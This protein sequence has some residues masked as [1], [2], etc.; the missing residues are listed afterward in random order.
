M[1]RAEAAIAELQAQLFVIST[2]PG[3]HPPYQNNH[4]LR[5]VG[6]P[7]ATT[8]KNTWRI[9]RPSSN[10]S[11]STG[12]AKSLIRSQGNKGGPDRAGGSG[13]RGD[14]G[15]GDSNDY[16]GI[17]L[18]S[19]V[20]QKC[21]KPN[22]SSIFPGLLVPVRSPSNS[23]DTNTFLCQENC[24]ESV[25]GETI[26]AGG[27]DP[28]SGGRKRRRKSSK[29]NFVGIENCDS[30]SR[31]DNVGRRGHSGGPGASS[32]NEGGGKDNDTPKLIAS[33]ISDAMSTDVWGLL[34]NRVHRRSGIAQANRHLLAIEVMREVSDSLVDWLAAPIFSSITNHRDCNTCLR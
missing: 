5:L 23:E 9:T 25:A 10:P 30:D 34:D 7:G 22:S 19:Q 32:G 2:Q 16:Q 6:R 20:S 13:T 29:G 18:M 31:N 33:G 14:T 4:S 8:T 12:R 27:L 26:A 15:K 3:P 1:K 11:H 28:S 24:S 17:D 21:C